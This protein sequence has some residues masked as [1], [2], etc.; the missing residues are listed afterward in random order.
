MSF[1]HPEAFFLLALLALFVL[2]A[3][4]NFK[5]K[6]SLLENFVS[7]TAYKR[8][9]LRSGSEIDF[10][11]TALVTLAM[12]FFIFALAGPQ[13]GEQFENIDV[14]GIEMIFL[15]DTSA[16]MNAEDLKP[17]R[18]EVS[19]QLVTTIVDTLDTDYVG[20]VNFA[21]V[22]YVQCPL[23]NDY[24]A[25]KYMTE[26]SFI[27]FDEEQGTDFKEAIQ[28]GIKTFQKS[29]SDTKLL[30]FITDGE[31]QEQSWQELK[32]EMEKE[33]IMVF[34]FGVGVPEGAP[35]PIKNKNGEITGWKKDKSGNIIKTRL[36]EDTLIRIAN[37]TGGKYFRLSDAA[38][39]DDFARVLKEYERSVIN[40]KVKLK[41]ID[42]FHY[43][44]IIGLILLIIELLLSEKRLKWQKKQEV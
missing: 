35:I 23:T 22:A 27:S 28:L 13:W 40:K 38:S 16:S 29:E 39:I 1:L 20:L 21:G 41:K 26:A 44:L 10:F 18:L 36:A 33:K 7:A 2:V 8:L 4:Y 32:T 12:A 15:M 17:N 42:R 37:T 19:K 31:D 3:A 30:I 5:K 11:K 9:A 43:P 6:K 24:E 25:F 34:A 14:K